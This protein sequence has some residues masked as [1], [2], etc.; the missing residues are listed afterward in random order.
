MLSIFKKEINSFFSSLIGYIVIGVFLLFM[1]AFMWVFPD[2]SILNYGFATLHQLFDFAPWIFCFL[3]PAITMRSFAEETQSGTIELLATRP[4]T[5]IQI[6]LGKFFANWLLVIIALIPT[7][8]YYYTVHQLGA[9]VGNIDAGEVAG[10][11]LGLIF[12]AGSFVA[13]GLFSSSLTNNQIVAFVLGIFLCFFFYMAFDFLST[14]SSNDHFIELFGINYH[15]NL[16]S[17]GAV[18]SR[19]VIYFVTF[20]TGFIFFTKTALE[21]RNW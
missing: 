3:I 4:I 9:P 8:L 18:D 20:I 17:R 10:S 13:I 6:I 2:Y 15:Y 21:R 14:L 5:D 11:Y 19:D 12:L 7:L 1:G 16:L